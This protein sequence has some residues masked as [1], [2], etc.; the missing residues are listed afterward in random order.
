[1]TRTAYDDHNPPAQPVN[2]EDYRHRTLLDGG[3][4][5]APTLIVWIDSDPLPFDAITGNMPTLGPLR[6]VPLRRTSGAPA[7]LQQKCGGADLTAGRS[8][9]LTITPFI[10]KHPTM[11]TH[12][13]IRANRP[14]APA[15]RQSWAPRTPRAAATS[16]CIWRRRTSPLIV[17]SRCWRRPPAA[18]PSRI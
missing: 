9:P 14:N 13:A 12:T 16:R 17:P 3:D 2:P 18:E 4:A 15:G 6:P 11:T 8:P 10:M 5:L 7:P 1:M